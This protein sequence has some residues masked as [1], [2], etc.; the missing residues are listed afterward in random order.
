M[1]EL[2]FHGRRQ[3]GDRGLARIRRLQAGPSYGSLKKKDGN[4]ARRCVMNCQTHGN[5]TGCGHRVRRTAAG[6]QKSTAH[7]RQHKGN[8]TFHLESSRN[9][10][11]LG[12][13]QTEDVRGGRLVLSI[14]C[15]TTRM[16]CFT[17]LGLPNRP[18]NVQ[19]DGGVVNSTF[20]Q[21]AC[22]SYNLPAVS[23]TP[24]THMPCGCNYK[25]VGSRCV[26]EWSPE[27]GAVAW[28]MEFGSAGFLGIALPGLLCNQ[29][30]SPGAPRT[31]TQ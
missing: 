5:T 20:R 7:K 9:S 31:R 15:R 30:D 28:S 29:R 1:P 25:S 6:S 19:E 10:A 26:N 13:A 12:I 14:G 4:A 2:D 23:G 11:D 17:A 16:G 8:T 24:Q 27:V 18:K 21:L 22:F 3:D